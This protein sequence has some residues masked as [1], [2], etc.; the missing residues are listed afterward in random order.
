MGGLA[1]ALFLRGSGWSVE[2]FERA[3]RLP[4]TG[5]AL[6]LWPTALGTTGPGARRPS[7]WCV[8][9]G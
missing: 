7:G 5:T 4:A 2:V 3:D 9:R 6:G 1:T 8:P